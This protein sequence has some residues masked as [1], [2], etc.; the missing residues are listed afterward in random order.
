MATF[1][2]RAN[3]GQYELATPADLLKLLATIA[4]RKVINQAHWH[5]AGRRDYRREEALGSRDG[6]TPADGPDPGE[7]VA[8]RELLEKVRERLSDDERRLAERRGRGDTW[9]EIAADQGGSGESLRKKLVRALD[10][11]LRQLGLNEGGDE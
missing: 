2:V 4:R 8:A 9:A 1:F 10:R 11:V 5:R 7:Q 3:L 6:L